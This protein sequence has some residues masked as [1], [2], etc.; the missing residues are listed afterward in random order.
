[1][2]FATMLAAVYR[3]KSFSAEFINIAALPKNKEFQS[4]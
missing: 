4:K 3:F 2:L 1:M